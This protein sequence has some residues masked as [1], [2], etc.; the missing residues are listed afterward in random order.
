MASAPLARSIPRDERSRPEVLAADKSWRVFAGPGP[1]RAA[2]SRHRGRPLLAVH[3]VPVY[4]VLSL[5]ILVLTAATLFWVALTDLRE[6]KVRN[7]RRDP[8]RTLCRP[9]PFIGSVGV[10]AVEFRL[11]APDAGRR[12][13]CLFA[14]ANWRRRSETAGGRLPVDRSVVRR[15]VRDPSLD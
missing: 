14:S 13:L 12:G 1:D 6:F 15:A 5:W 10:D 9:C 11:C 3:R 7:F 8:G 4:P 2:R